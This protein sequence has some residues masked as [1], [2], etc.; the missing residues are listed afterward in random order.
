MGVAGLIRF[1][2]WRR[3]PRGIHSRTGK[4]SF[5]F[6]KL[7][8]ETNLTEK[9]TK[10][11][12]RAGHAGA[13]AHDYR[14][15]R[16]RFFGTDAYDRNTPTRTRDM[17]ASPAASPA[18]WT[19]TRARYIR[20]SP[21]RACRCPARRLDRRRRVARA[22]DADSVA[23]SASYRDLLDA[24]VAR[25]RELFGDLLPPEGLEVYASP[26]TRGF[27]QRC[28][29]A[30]VREPSVSGDARA[31]STR[32]NLRYALFERGRVV[33]VDAR[34]E[35]AF[36]AASR[37]ISELMPRV[38]DALNEEDAN[39]S[40]RDPLGARPLT[41]NLS[42]V[43]FLA[44]RAGD[45]VVTLWNATSPKHGEGVEATRRDGGS[46][47]A[48][49][50]SDARWH[51]A[52]TAFRESLGLKGVVCRRKK[53]TLACGADRV[54]ETAAVPS[55]SSLRDA[56]DARD[57]AVAADGASDTLRLCLVEGAFSNP[58]ADVAERTAGWLRETTRR[59]LAERGEDAASAGPGPGNRT[60]LTELYCG[61]GTHTVTLARAF[62]AVTAVEI[63]P[64]LCAAAETNFAA[65]GV[66]NASVEATPAETFSAARGGGDDETGRPRPNDDFILVDPPRAGLDPATVALVRRYRTVVYIA[67]DSRSLVRD[68]RERGLGETHELRRAAVFDH[69][70]TSEFCEV[71]VWA[72]RRR[73]T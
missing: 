28:R 23:G 6:D 42:A 22:S 63:E 12:F 3:F 1:F 14:R 34:D 53:K 70:P 24:K 69:F 38:L 68:L 51:A 73:E 59:A 32:G 48:D 52:A 46:A 16:Q 33:V 40:R 58:N 19:P 13:L 44:N 8:R 11:G 71:V 31:R 47:S 36:G 60:R 10:K 5:A 39:G 64:R 67:C 43:G 27:R 56:A 30:V 45:V 35:N 41:E 26:K 57:T 15:P 54:W 49:D 25:T 62:R 18:A 72:E 66:T 21:A 65:N 7:L 61:N 20:V 55:F 29:F 2:C 9:A 50:E 4:R 17:S 37:P